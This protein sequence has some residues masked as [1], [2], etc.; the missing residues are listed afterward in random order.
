MSNLALRIAEIGIKNYSAKEIDG[1]NAVTIVLKIACL[2][3]F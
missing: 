2:R 3:I 1:A